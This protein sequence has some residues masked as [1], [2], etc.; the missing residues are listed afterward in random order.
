MQRQSGPG[1]VSRGFESL[2]CGVEAVTCDDA[3]RG[4]APHNNGSAVR[5]D[6]V[7]KRAILVQESISPKIA[8][9][10]PLLAYTYKRGL[11]RFVPI[12]QSR[13]APIAINES[14]RKP[15]RIARED[16]V[17]DNQ[18]VIAE[19]TCI[20]PLCSGKVWHCMECTVAVAFEDVEISVGIL[21]FAQ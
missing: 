5:E 19:S 9:D 2:A 10:H 6:N 11:A 16:V 20:G 18:A 13:K 4:N 3:V 12:I 21:I 15:G 7:L 1:D 17:A 14:V 8:C